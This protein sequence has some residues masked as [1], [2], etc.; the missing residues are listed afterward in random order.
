M[1]PVKEEG[2]LSKAYNYYETRISGWSNK[3]QWNEVNCWIT[4]KKELMAKQEFELISSIFK[5]DTFLKVSLL[6][7][8]I[9][10]G[11]ITLKLDDLN[12]TT[13]VLHSVP[14]TTS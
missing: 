13:K 7:I 6:Y 2:S 11:K 8:F 14:I 9:L 4:K 1:R 12:V 5:S 3:A 10:T